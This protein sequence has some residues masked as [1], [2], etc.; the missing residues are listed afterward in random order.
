MGPSLTTRLKKEKKTAQKI[1]SGH[2]P[3]DKFDKPGRFLKDPN[4]FGAFFREETPIITAEN[5][6]PPHPKG[7]GWSQEA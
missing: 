6:D 5:R 3:G 1:T 4:F 7:C 2:F